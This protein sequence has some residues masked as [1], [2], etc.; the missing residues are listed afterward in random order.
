MSDSD[1]LPLSPV[2]NNSF[3]K[4]KGGYALNQVMTFK[5]SNMQRIM[6]MMQRMA[7]KSCRRAF[8]LFCCPIDTLLCEKAAWI[9]A[10]EHQPTEA[11]STQ[12]ALRN[13]P[14]TI[15][16]VNISNSTLI[17]CVIGNDTYPSAVAESQPLV[18]EPELHLHDHMRCNCNHGQW[19]TPLPPVCPLLHHKIIRE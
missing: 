16:I 13:P 1:P 19:E 12:V 5:V 14:S 18:Q 9:P 17:D 8:Q 11:K 7:Q 3:T 6:H 2:N 10:Q 15:L 4:M